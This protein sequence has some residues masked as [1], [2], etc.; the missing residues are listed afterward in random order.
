VDAVVVVE[1]DRSDLECLFVVAVAALDVA[2]SS[3]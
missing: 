3:G 1:E 2:V